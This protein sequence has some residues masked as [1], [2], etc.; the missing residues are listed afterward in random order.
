[1]KYTYHAQ[2]ARQRRTLIAGFGG[3]KILSDLDGKIEIRG[4]TP[5]E[6]AQARAWQKQFLTRTPPC[7]AG[8]P[9]GAGG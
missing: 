6:Q 2:Q 7:H 1:M 4:G 9:K 8:A 3:A 5:E